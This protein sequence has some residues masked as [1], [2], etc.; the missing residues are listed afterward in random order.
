MDYSDLFNKCINV[1]LINEG[2]YSNHPSDPGG[3]TNMGVT[4]NVYNNYR[5]KSGLGIQSVKLISDDEVYEIYFSLYWIPMKLEQI[6]NKDLVLQVFDMGV[7][8]G[9]RTSI[10]ILQ[11][12]IK[13]SDDGYIGPATVM[14]IE[15][16]NGNIVEDFTQRRKKFYNALTNAKP[17]LKVF[18]KGWIN[19]VENTKFTVVII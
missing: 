13:V 2:G 14:A 8:S 9:I 5:T 15:K 17:E 1:I 7:N 19:R 3:A 6:N 12:L 4:Q 18:L 11:R 10:K 16:Y